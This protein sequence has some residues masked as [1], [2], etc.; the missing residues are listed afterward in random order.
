MVPT[1]VVSILQKN[2]GYKTSLL[3]AYHTCLYFAVNVLQ[4]AYTFIRGCKVLTLSHN[5]NMKDPCLKS[6]KD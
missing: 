2:G 3:Y 5:F 6:N 4:G 1:L